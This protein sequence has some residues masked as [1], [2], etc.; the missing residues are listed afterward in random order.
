MTKKT[1]YLSLGLK[2]DLFN[3]GARRICLCLRE[4]KTKD[5]YL[6]DKTNELDELRNELMQV[7]HFKANM[8]SVREE[9][10]LLRSRMTGL[11]RQIVWWSKF[12]SSMEKASA[13]RLLSIVNQHGALNR[14]V[15]RECRSVAETLLRDFSTESAQSDIAVLSGMQN[16]V[17]QLSESFEVLCEKQNAVDINNST[18]AK[19]TLLSEI[20]G[21]VA[22]KIN[23]IMAYI[24]GNVDARPQE[25]GS[26]LESLLTILNDAN[27]PHVVMQVAAEA[28]PTIAAAE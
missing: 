25:F 3:D 15:L 28:A 22:K 6:F 23:V 2:G 1:N 7:L 13:T 16:L 5:A 27:K 12:G 10:I 9:A 4:T 26:L 8:E 17:D 20:K 18:W 19:T 11:K 24:E 21:A 14:L